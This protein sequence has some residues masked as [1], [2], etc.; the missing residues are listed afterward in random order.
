[1]VIFVPTCPVASNKTGRT[2]SR[3][4][5]PEHKLRPGSCAHMA[6]S[7]YQRTRRPPDFLEAAWNHLG[8]ES[9][10]APRKVASREYV[11]G[12]G[13]SWVADSR[14][15]NVSKR[16]TKEST[17]R[18]RGTEFVGFSEEH[19]TW[20]TGQRGAD[21]GRQLVKTN[22]DTQAKGRVEWVPVETLPVTFQTLPP[23]ADM[24]N[25][26]PQG[27]PPKNNSEGSYGV[28]NEYLIWSA[29]S[30]CSSDHQRSQNYSSEVCDG[31]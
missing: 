23:D 3:S 5:A 28:K 26:P 15:G 21:A 24:S 14:N 27:Y 22:C 11:I 12:R 10:L 19:A 4:R 30:S 7:N 18:H 9:R 29:Q 2:L 13:I 20:R 25:N 31:Q 6:A 1:M 8:S 16:R 17:Q